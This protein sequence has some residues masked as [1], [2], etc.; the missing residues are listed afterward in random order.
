MSTT[1]S[2]AFPRA[3]VAPFALQRRHALIW[4]AASALAF[5]LPSGAKAQAPLKVGTSGGPVA[6]I[7]QFAANHAGKNE[8]PVQ[9]IEFSDWITP[10][11]ALANGEI[12]T[13]LF[14]HIPFLNAA[15]KARGYKL[16]PIALTYV[17][18]VG[19]F[20]KKIKTFDELQSG[21]TVA[22]ANDPV[23][24]AR[25]LRLFEKAG[26][27]K[28]KPGVGDDATV[29]DIVQNPK[30]LKFLELDAAQLPRVLD[31]VAVAMV[32]YGYL[33]RAGISP[34]TALISDGFGDPHYGL[35]FA[36]KTDRKDD[37]R[38]AKFVALFRSPEVK[39]FITA[40]YGKFIVPLW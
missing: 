33:V 4:L 16:T 26:V 14:Q 10:N 17:L 31:D 32:S 37:P 23:N 24:G 13:N 27:I 29:L 28:L 34:D 2:T 38:I 5:A 9:V 40:K 19:L 35:H 8:V 25:G 18:P 1:K 3:Q 20:S 12:D 7:M 21:A 39:E 22:I 36:A 11:E 6:E 30:R 15:I